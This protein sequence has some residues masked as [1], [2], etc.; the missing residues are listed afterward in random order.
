MVIL[1]VKRLSWKILKISS[2]WLARLM[3]I[4][5]GLKENLA[6]RLTRTICFR[7]CSVFVSSIFQYGGIIKIVTCYLLIFFISVEK[8]FGH[9]LFVCV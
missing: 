4:L 6:D 8:L 3:L 9:L 1:Q 7:G 5:R 2:G